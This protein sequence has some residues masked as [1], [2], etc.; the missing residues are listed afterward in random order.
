MPISP[1]KLHELIFDVPR[2]LAKH[3]TLGMFSEEEGESL[4]NLV[5]QDLRHVASV[6]DDSL[7]LRL[8]LE[9]HELRGKADRS[10]LQTQARLCQ[11]CSEL[12]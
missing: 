8:L 3:K 9:R 1:E 10:L 11:K 2:F 7:K 6:R 12:G 5:N 4:H